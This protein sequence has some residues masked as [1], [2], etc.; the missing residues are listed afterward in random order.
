M[1][2]E[3]VQKIVEDTISRIKILAVL[4][5]GSKYSAKLNVKIVLCSKVPFD[6]QKEIS[7]CSVP[8]SSLM[9]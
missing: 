1:N 4:E 7:S 3:E 5:N 8:L 9:P 6:E 2:E